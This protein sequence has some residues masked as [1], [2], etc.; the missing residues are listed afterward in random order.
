MGKQTIAKL[1]NEEGVLCPAE[2]KRAMGFNYHNPNKLDSTTYWSYSTINNLLHR[3][4]YTGNMVQGTKHQQLKSKQRMVDKDEWVIVKDKHEPIID[5]DTW[6]KAQI[7]L[8]KR[9]RKLD[10]ETNKN[11]FAGFVICG[12]CGRAMNKSMWTRSD[13]SKVYSMY[14]GTFK[15]YG[16]QYCTPHKIPMKVLEQVVL[17]DLKTIIQN[18]DNLREIVKEQNF[19]GANM[20]RATEAELN[21]LRTELERV[22]KIKKSVYEDYKEELITKEEFLSYREDYLKKEELYTKQIETLEKKQNENI[23]E[24]VF[25]IPWIKRLLEL[26]DIEKLDRDIIVEMITAIRVYEGFKIKITYNFS[27]ELEHLFSN[28][29]NESLEEK[30]I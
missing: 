2:Y 29:Y 20:K 28:I 10:L 14:C 19:T 6:E 13:G 15:R 18:V 21:Q 9:T 23:E 22:R 5:R 16:K 8:K 4:I 24:D 30:V 7:L 27:N 1:L 11:I 26:R 3:E 12:D 17:S 25:E